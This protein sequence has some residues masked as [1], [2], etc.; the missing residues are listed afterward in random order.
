MRK[1][2]LSNMEKLEKDTLSDEKNFEKEFVK[3]V[4]KKIETLYGVFDPNYI[5]K[6]VRWLLIVSI[7]IFF[8]IPLGFFIWNSIT[9]KFDWWVNL[10][11]LGF[12][13][14]ASFFIISFLKD[15][16]SK[17]YKAYVYFYKI[18]DK[19]ITIY[20]QVKDKHITIYLSKK[21]IFRKYRNGD[22]TEIDYDEDEMMGRDL[23]FPQLKSD[24]YYEERK[25]GEHILY[26]YNKELRKRTTIMKIQNGVL[27]SIK[28]CKLHY[29]EFRPRINSVDLFTVIEINSSRNCDIPRSFLEFCE[30]RGIEFPKENEYLYF[31]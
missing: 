14:F 7:S 29:N 16:L 26:S 12:V 30:A 9:H 31:V 2:S 10:V 20:K 22:W 3:D 25:N 11:M 8:G 6:I 13:V 28:H 21:K 27:K 17:E 4:Y 24:L 15:F 18:G 5:S 23:L 1:I 19:T